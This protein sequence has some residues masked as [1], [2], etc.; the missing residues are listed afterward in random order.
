MGRKG[1]REKGRGGGFRSERSLFF[2][3]VVIIHH[4]YRTLTTIVTTIPVL[5]T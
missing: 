4:T 3:V 1:E 5:H 2:Y